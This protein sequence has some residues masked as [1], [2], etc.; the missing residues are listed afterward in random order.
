MMISLSARLTIV[1]LMFMSLSCNQHAKAVVHVS[2][3]KG[4]SLSGTKPESTYSE[5][6]LSSGRH[7]LVFNKQGVEYVTV[8]LVKGG[9]EIYVA[10]EPSD[11]YSP[12]V[13]KELSDKD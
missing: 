7:I 11:F 6:R 13:A 1:I 8:L 12:V 10:L 2:Y 9:G 4:Y 3:P 5:L